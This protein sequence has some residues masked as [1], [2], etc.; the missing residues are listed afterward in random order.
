MTDEPHPIPEDLRPLFQ[1]PV[2]AGELDWS[3]DGE[4]RCAACGRVYPIRDGIPDFVPE[5]DAG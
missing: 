3:R 2:C 5:D 4:I 1:C